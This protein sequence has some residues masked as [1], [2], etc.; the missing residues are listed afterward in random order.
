M[1]ELTCTPI[2]IIYNICL[3]ANDLRE[4]GELYEREYCVLCQAEEELFGHSKTALNGV[5]RICNE[6]DCKYC[7]KCVMSWLATVILRYWVVW[8]YFIRIL[9]LVFFLLIQTITEEEDN[10]VDFSSENQ[11][12]IQQFLIY[13]FIYLFIHSFI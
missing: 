12:E 3:V 10:N 6:Q 5:C 4:K 2:S 13:L 8:H 7:R 11:S 1:R 9:I